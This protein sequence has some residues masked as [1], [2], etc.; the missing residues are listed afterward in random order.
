MK[1][2]GWKQWGS[3]RRA[4]RYILTPFHPLHFDLSLLFHSFISFVKALHSISSTSLLTVP[5][6]PFLYILHYCPSLHFVSCS[7]HLIHS[8]F[9]SHLSYDSFPS[10]SILLYLLHLSFLFPFLYC[11]SIL[12]LIHHGSPSLATLTKRSLHFFSP[13]PHSR[14]Q[15]VS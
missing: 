5:P 3:E 13:I 7:L 11:L 10:L 14:L 6:L 1:M 4:K 8:F 12:L 9:T 15:T 2:E